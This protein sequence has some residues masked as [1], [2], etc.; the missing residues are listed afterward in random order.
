MTPSSNISFSYSNQIYRFPFNLLQKKIC[1]L[2]QIKY[3]KF[4]V[5]SKHHT[6]PIINEGNTEL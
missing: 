1:P 3:V 4:W 5:I 2:N 6:F